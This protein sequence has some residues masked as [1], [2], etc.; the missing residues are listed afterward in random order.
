VDFFWSDHHWLKAAVLYMTVH[1][2][3]QGLV[4]LE[5]RMAAFRLKA[6]QRL[7]YHTDVG[8]REPACALLRRAAVPH[9]AGEAG[10]QQVSQIFTL[11]C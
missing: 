2:G 6:V 10:V 4:E 3:R 7:M 8:W 1:E 9:G 5:S 11:Q